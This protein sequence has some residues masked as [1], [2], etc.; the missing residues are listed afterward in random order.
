MRGFSDEERDQIRQDLIDAGRALFPRFGLQKTTISDLTDEVGIGRSTFYRF[1][2]S[3]EELY[4]AVLEAEGEQVSQRLADENLTAVDDAQ[5]VVERFL[6]FIFDEIETN[7]LVR[8]LIIS[9]ELDRLR[10]HRTEAEREAERRSEIKTIRAFLDPLVEQGQL[11]EDDPELVASALAAIPYLTLHEDDIGADRYPDV[12]DV[13]I[14][15]FARG[16]VKDPE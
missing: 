15:T 3:K 10:A 6:R 1:F 14:E 2:D 12:R 11:H 8:Q 4:L 5:V 16:L 9:G 13:V 7:P